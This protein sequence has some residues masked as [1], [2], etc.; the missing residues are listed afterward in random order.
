M[1]GLFPATVV[2][3][4]VI[5]R[6]LNGANHVSIMG[7]LSEFRKEFVR[8]NIAGWAILLPILSVG[9]WI[10]TSVLHGSNLTATVTV[11][12]GVP[13]VILGMLLLYSTLVQ[14]SI[15]STVSTNADIRNGLVLLTKDWQA[16]LLGI[17]V[18]VGTVLTTVLLP[19]VSLFYFVTPSFLTT[20][21]FLW[22]RKEELNT[23]N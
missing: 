10:Q 12:V 8:T 22:W 2:V 14:M 4:T 23:S 11:A 15:Y 5:R 9:W 17:G 6:Y 20:I 18:F 13:F 19:I 3:C 1:A 21:A 7:L 16:P